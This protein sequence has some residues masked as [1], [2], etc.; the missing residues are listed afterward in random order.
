MLPLV[1]PGSAKHTVALYTQNV[2]GRG[3]LFAQFSEFR[4][5]LNPTLKILASYKYTILRCKKHVKS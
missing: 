5:A 1:L 3:E 4:D 2:W